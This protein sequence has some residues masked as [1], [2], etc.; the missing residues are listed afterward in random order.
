MHRAAV[1]TIDHLEANGGPHLIGNT[2]HATKASVIIITATGQSPHTQF[3]ARNAGHPAGV[4]RIGLESRQCA[5][6]GTD[7]EGR[8]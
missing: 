4:S 6:L 5:H 3:V 2:F 8:G 1:S 7:E